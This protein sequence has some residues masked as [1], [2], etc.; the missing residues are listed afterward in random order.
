MKTKAQNKQEKPA[1]MPSTTEQIAAINTRQGR[2]MEKAI[3][4]VRVLRCRRDGSRD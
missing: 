4:P 3:G 1:A 2:E